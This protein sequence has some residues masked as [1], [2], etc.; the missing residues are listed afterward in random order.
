MSRSHGID[1][2]TNA[3]KVI[4]RHGVV[5]L[6]E[7]TWAE[8]AE[9]W[10]RAEAVGFQHAWTFDHL[11]WRWLREATWFAALP[12]LTAAAG[13]THRIRLGTLVASP[14]LRHPL[15]FAKE[16]MT[17]DD[18]SSGRA[19]CGIGAGADGYDTEV[20]G[21]SRLAPPDR[22]TRFAE[23]V[24]LTDLLL[25][26]PETTY[27]GRHYQAKAAQMRPGCVQRPRVPIAIAAC[28]RHGMRLTARSAQIWVTNGLPGR[29]EHRRFDQAAA[30]LREQLG[31]LEEACAAEGRD[32]A[33]LDRLVLAGIQIG[34]VLASRD[35]FADA[36]G[37]FAELGFTDMVV[38]WPRPD[39]PF[40]GRPEI[41][42]EI[43]PLM[44]R[45][46]SDRTR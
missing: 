18:I 19:I 1:I 28:G 34:G 6:P 45:A 9:R 36:E 43:A 39:F 40:A 5:I 20:F 27:L 12:T 25:R 21:G 16:M 14:N 31:R 7:A 26:Q 35:A 11:G 2:A 44:S 29:F 3:G 10:Q 22:A 15:T 4:V 42:D 8:A 37:M 46:A 13:V 17:L 33:S 32:P 30:T 41:L 23:F 38:P 24:E